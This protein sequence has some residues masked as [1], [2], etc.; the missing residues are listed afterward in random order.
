[1][2]FL[3]R[4]RMALLLRIV[5]KPKWVPPDWVAAGDVPADAL[6]DLRA[7]N[8]ELSVWRVELDQSNLNA[9]IVAAASNRDRLDKLDYVLFDEAILPAIPIKCVRSEGNTPHVSANA[10][11]H[12]DLIELT[13]RTIAR[14]A[15]E[16]MPL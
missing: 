6:S 13:V 8:N 4:S 10:E 5:T 16:M 2:N 11:I 1:M 7:N 3:R 12:S 14:L 15:H 9:A